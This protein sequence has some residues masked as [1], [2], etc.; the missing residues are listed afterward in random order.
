MAGTGLGKKSIMLWMTEVCT[1][2][3]STCISVNICNWKR[4]IWF[5]LKKI[6]IRK[7]ERKGK[8]L[9]QE[10][11]QLKIL[12]FENCSMW[13]A[14]WE[15]KLLIQTLNHE[16]ALHRIKMILSFIEHMQKTLFP[17]FTGSWMVNVAAHYPNSHGDDIIQQF[18]IHE[19][20]A[21]H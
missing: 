17:S 16:S 7:K 18:G 11:L 10:I 21:S 13:P 15:S 20:L 6:T 12:I 2:S 9:L 1:W 14:F 5:A 8:A 19:M 3:M 4:L